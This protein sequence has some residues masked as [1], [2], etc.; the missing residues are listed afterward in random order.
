MAGVGETPRLGLDPRSAGV[1][2]EVTEPPIRA[3]AAVR[4]HDRVADL[5]R[6]SGPLVE[7]TVQ[8]EPAADTG[9]HPDA[10]EV[11]VRTTRRRASTRRGSRR[12][13]R[14]RAG[15]RGSRSPP[16]ASTRTRRARRPR[17]PGGW[18][19]SPTVPASP[20][21]EP[22]MP[23][24]AAETSSLDRR[25]PRAPHPRPRP[26]RRR[27]PRGRPRGSW[28]E[29]SRGSSS[30]RSAAV[31]IFVPPMSMPIVISAIHPPAIRA[32]VGGDG[33]DMQEPGPRTGFRR[34]RGRQISRRRG[35]SPRRAH[36]LVRSR[37]RR[38]R[39]RGA[40]CSLGGPGWP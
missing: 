22:G 5:P 20:S 12:G 8:D 7:P 9:A 17:S 6:G 36:P 21:T 26:P 33:P 29:R 13:R 30:P 24:P 25:P 10:E 2:L 31:W 16:R 40:G 1:R 38:A 18:G 11:P 37:P 4:L 3:D 15:R 14:S 27:A 35:R 39:T 34:G 28:S 32:M 19:S 23:A